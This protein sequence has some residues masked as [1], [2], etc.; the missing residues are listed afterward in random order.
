MVL[1]PYGP[2][3][4]DL[5]PIPDLLVRARHIVDNLDNRRD[6]DVKTWWAR[7][8]LLNLEHLEIRMGYTPLTGDLGRVVAPALRTY[9]LRNVFIPF[10][11]PMLQ[12][13]SI[14]QKMTWT[15]LLDVVCSCP[16]LTVLRIKSAEPVDIATLSCEAQPS[17]VSFTCLKEL[18][19]QKAVHSGTLD[20]LDHLSFPNSIDFSVH[21]FPDGPALFH[22]L[23]ARAQFQYAHRDVLS[24][25][26]SSPEEAEAEY[27]VELIIAVSEG[28]H[29]PYSEYKRAPQGG[30]QL[31]TMLDEDDDMQLANMLFHFPGE[32]ARTIRTLMLRSGR[33]CAFEGMD[34]ILHDPLATVSRDGFVHLWRAMSMF[35]EVETIYFLDPR[36]P[37]MF[38]LIPHPEYQPGAN[39]DAPSEPATTPSQSYMAFPAL[40]T[41]VID[42]KHR[43]LNIDDWNDLFKVIEMRKTD[44]R[45]IQRVVFMGD[46]LCHLVMGEG[47]VEKIVVGLHEQ[48]R[49]VMPLQ[50]PPLASLKSL[51][52][53]VDLRA[54]GCQ[55]SQRDWIGEYPLP[56]QPGEFERV[57]SDEDAAAKGYDVPRRIQLPLP[58][59]AG[60]EDA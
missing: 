29:L 43:R 28:H 9:I 11:A 60:Q 16:L 42:T 25:T 5:L 34:T 40:H 44:E 10:E 55:C 39:E 6:A 1:P 37:S 27:S 3:Y 53:V 54:E 48:V 21:D 58:S 19:M 14:Y 20:F 51:V 2:N 7:S 15:D 52:E 26:T 35:N 36:E 4:F 33:S 45:P 41:I 22:A 38:L 56:V 12:S 30:L 17:A 8:P 57:M 18:S 31:A 13:L 47:T 24:I 46:G 50:E 49:V 59:F 23:V 32:S